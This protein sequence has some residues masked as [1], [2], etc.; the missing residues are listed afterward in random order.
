MHIK[1]KPTHVKLQDA[2]PKAPN[3]AGV[4]VVLALIEI[5]VDPLR[6]H[7]GYGPHRGVAGVHRLRQD[8]A[9]TEIGNLDLISIVD[10]EIRRLD[11]AVDD[12]PSVEVSQAGEDLPSQIGDSFLVGDVLPL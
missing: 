3:I 10:Q 2:D 1:G 4:G 11:V 8:S 7:V 12:A 9:H 6:A 5:G